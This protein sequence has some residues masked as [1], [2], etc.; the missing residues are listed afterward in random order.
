M[1]GL[2]V[3]AV[4]AV[5]VCLVAVA[6]AAALV[7]RHRRIA[8]VADAAAWREHFAARGGHRRSMDRYDESKAS[9]GYARAQRQTPAGRRIPTALELQ[10]HEARR[11]RQSVSAV[12]P[13]EARR[14]RAGG[15]S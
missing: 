9:A 3:G 2:A 13:I 8:D 7:R 12:V 1:T 14:R 5:M 4:G 11:R 15:S 6:V 10:K